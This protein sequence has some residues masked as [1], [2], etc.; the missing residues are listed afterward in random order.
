MLS[1]KMTRD[2]V[3]E[4]MEATAAERL[5]TEEPSGVRHLIFV[6]AVLLAFG[7][8]VVGMSA[9]SRTTVDRDRQ[10]TLSVASRWGAHP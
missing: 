1:S 3:H 10:G 9:L 2:L 7:S 5:P 6:V 8:F 4:L